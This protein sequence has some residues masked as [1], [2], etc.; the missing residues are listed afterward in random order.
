[1]K[2]IVLQWLIYIAVFE[3]EL[4][5][6]IIF[7]E[8]L[9]ISWTLLGLNF[10]IELDVL[11]GNCATSSRR[12]WVWANIAVLG[13]RHLDF[14]IFVG[15][16]SLDIVAILDCCRIFGRRSLAIIVVLR[17]HCLDHCHLCWP[18]VFSSRCRLGRWCIQLSSQHEALSIIAW[19][20]L[21]SAN[22]DTMH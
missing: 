2:N 4:L 9:N 3:D 8:N 15:R 17:S 22:T 21:S 12:V 20:H 11:M 13:S 10:K 18:S 16:Q 5:G 14:A 19:H 7:I 6:M 1:M